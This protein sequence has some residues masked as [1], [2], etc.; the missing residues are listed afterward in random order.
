MRFGHSSRKKLSIDELEVA[1]GKAEGRPRVK[2][3]TIPDIFAALGREHQS[4][5][6]SENERAERQNI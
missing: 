2:Y 1:R 4:V 5:S 3:T 6:G